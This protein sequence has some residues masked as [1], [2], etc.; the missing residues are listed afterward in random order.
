MKRVVMASKQNRNG[1]YTI[2]KASFLADYVF[3]AQANVLGVLAVIKAPP[4]RALPNKTG[5]GDVAGAFLLVNDAKSVS[6]LK[7]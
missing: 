3:K 4:Y 2:G 7:P 1:D 6:L 5:C